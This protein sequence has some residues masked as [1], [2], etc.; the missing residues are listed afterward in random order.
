MKLGS[1]AVLCRITTRACEPEPACSNAVCGVMGSPQMGQMD[2]AIVTRVL[3]DLQRYT[4]LLTLILG[5]TL[6]P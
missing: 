3:Q 1:A 2:I 5:L 4:A 6:T